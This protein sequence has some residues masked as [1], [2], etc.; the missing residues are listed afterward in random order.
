MRKK[1]LIRQVSFVVLLLL[2]FA[3]CNNP[4][5]DAAKTDT[6]DSSVVVAPAA[7]PPQGSLIAGNLD[8]VWM[9]SATFV[10]LGA[11][12][13]LTFRFYI[14]NPNNISLR[15]WTGNSNS[16]DS[17]PD[18]YLKTGRQSKVTFGSGSYF[19]N[20]QLSPSN[21]NAI[22]Q[23]LQDTKTKY[24]VFG[25]VNPTTGVNAGQILYKIYVTNDYPGNSTPSIIY[26][27]LVEDTGIETNPSP[28]K[29][30]N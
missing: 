6:P 14:D 20:L 13:R 17:P 29:N 3:S 12:T 11:G 5:T 24:V 23:K 28:P 9:D 30:S 15:G 19:G 18:V 1:F 4:E 21:Y 8:T 7:A 25:P 16:W 10:N 2:L 26:K 27:F 22:K